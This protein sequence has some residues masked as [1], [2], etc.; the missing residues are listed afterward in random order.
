MKPRL[1]VVIATYNRPESLHR[2]LLQLAQ[3]TMALAEFEVIVVDDGSRTSLPQ[4]AAPYRLTVLRQ[5]NQGAAVALHLGANAA[6]ADIL[7]IVDDDMEVSPDLL[8]E[9][10][11]LQESDEKAVVLGCI[12]SPLGTAMP[13]FERFHARYFTRIA[14]EM[15]SGKHTLTGIDVWTGNLSMRRAQYLKVGGFD[16]ELKLSQDAE[17][18]LRLEKDGATFYLS[19]TAYS[20]QHSDHTSL[21][22]WMNRSYRYGRTDLRISR[23]HP[24]IRHA[25]P[26]RYCRDITPISALFLILAMA[27]PAAAHVAARAAMSI[28]K[29]LD[30]MGLEHAALMATELAFGMEYTRGLHD[31]VGGFRAAVHEVRLFYRAPAC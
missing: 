25:S 11:R 22:A 28:A 21:A 6:V 29:S 13:L 27:V 30:A 15:Q 23:K 4:I 16:Q 8:S 19:E 5:E 12:R 14:H 1:S 7:L 26:W 10:L 18:G 20:I 2:L 24:D 3:Q 9:H 17:L 31:E